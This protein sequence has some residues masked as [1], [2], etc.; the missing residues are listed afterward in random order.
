MPQYV[1]QQGEEEESSF[2]EATQAPAAPLAETARGAGRDM[3]ATMERIRSSAGEPKL[4]PVLATAMI[5]NGLT[6]TKANEKRLSEKAAE[7][8]QKSTVTMNADG[9][10][11]VTKMPA[12]DFIES[13]KEQTAGTLAGVYAT[14]QKLGLA[15]AM[16]PDDAA[17]DDTPEFQ[18]FYNAG[19][20]RGWSPRQ[21]RKQAARAMKDPEVGKRAM[22]WIRDNYAQDVVNRY[23]F[24]Q[25]VIN[26]A[27]Q[28]AKEE[29][30]VGA[31]R[32]RLLNQIL[33]QGV[34][35]LGETPAEAVI[36]ARERLGTITEGEEKAIKAQYQK[37]RE[38]AVT[39]R[40][41]AVNSRV[42]SIR[43]E[44]VRGYKPNQIEQFIADQEADLGPLNAAQKIGLTKRFEGLQEKIAIQLRGE[45]RRDEQL[46]AMWKRLEGGS[47]DKP[48]KISLTEAKVAD[49]DDLLAMKGDPRVDQAVL[50]TRLRTK[51][52]QLQAREKSLTRDI[53]GK[54]TERTAVSDRLNPEKAAKLDADLARMMSERDEVRRQLDAMKKPADGPR[55]LSA[56]EALERLK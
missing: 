36:A 50:E 25:P 32:R 42:T 2:A 24:A 52:S 47:V 44:D 55:V 34:M 16:K 14:L 7:L 41:Q 8:D 30:L 13:A 12:A 20:Q 10:F 3:L 22:Q 4:N 21:S 56:E 33:D 5:A 28:D 54:R 23:K 49:V 19:L 27:Q 37:E 17:L 1:E 38:K 29:R 35:T 11:S 15:P 31:E 53:V 6:A 26:D 43:D 39:S 51:N 40:A 45:K 18:E 48:E 9:T 46:S